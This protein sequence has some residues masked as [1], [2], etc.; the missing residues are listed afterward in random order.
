MK[1]VLITLALAILFVPC[2]LKAAPV[3]MAAPVPAGVTAVTPVDDLIKILNPLMKLYTAIQA[4]GEENMTLEEM[5]KV[6]EYV[7]KL[8]NL[9]DN[10]GSYRL[11][12]ADREHMLGWAKQFAIDYM[13]ETPTAEDMAEA[14]ASLKEMKTLNDLL[15]DL[16]LDEMF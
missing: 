16:D 14:R 6:L 12:D 5:G 8:Q 7:G 10:Y 15:E 1:K 4:K 2:Q 9:K 3:A 13:G 11:T